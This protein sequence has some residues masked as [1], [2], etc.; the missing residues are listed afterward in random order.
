LIHYNAVEAT[1]IRERLL[2]RV[3]A[4]VATCYQCGNCSAGCPAAFT[5]DYAPN[6][7]MRMLQVGMVD[8]VLSSKA[9]QNCIQC[10]TCTARCP[11]EIDIAGIF[12]SLK[13]IAVAQGTS[14]PEHAA[15]FNRLFLQNI[16]RYGRLTE[17][18]FLV[19]FNLAA[20]DP[21]NDS[22][23]GLPMVSKGKIAVVPK[24]AK[25]ADEVGRIYKKA[26]EKARAAET[27]R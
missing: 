19:R 4:D 6:Q 9:V 22:S 12:E 26:M 16:A 10:L 8:E 3:K 1:S 27:A 21:L 5:F 17:A 23:L 18:L 11:R 2:S 20:M 14:V 25:G 7:V 15:T 24:K 13:T